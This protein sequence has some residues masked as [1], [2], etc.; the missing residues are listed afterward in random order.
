MVM[1]KPDGTAQVQ[2]LP[3]TI[4]RWPPGERVYG[5]PAEKAAKG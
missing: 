3:V 5:Q 2:Y 1:R 4:T